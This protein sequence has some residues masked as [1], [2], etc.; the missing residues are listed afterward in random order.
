MAHGTEQEDYLLWVVRD[1]T[2][3]LSYLGQQHPITRWVQAAQ[4]GQL[5]AQL[6][7]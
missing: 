3:L 2:S 4:R 5:E 6:I 1:M 7:A